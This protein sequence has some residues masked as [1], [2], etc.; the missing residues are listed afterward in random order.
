[1]KLLTGGA[2][3]SAREGDSGVPFRVP[4]RLGR[5]PKA[6]LGRMA[7]RWPFSYFLFSFSFLFLVFPISFITFANFT[8]FISNQLL[9]SFKNQHNVLNQ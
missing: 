1:M 5:W 7:P 3:P 6:R 9:N 2:A 8:Q 4:A